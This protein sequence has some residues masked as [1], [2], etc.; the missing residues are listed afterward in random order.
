MLDTCAETR[1]SV[2]ARDD[3]RLF[4]CSFLVICAIILINVVVAVLLEKMV[5]PIEEY[6]E[7]EQDH[8]EDALDGLVL[9]DL[10]RIHPEPPP[11]TPPR[12]PDLHNTPVTELS[13]GNEDVTQRLTALE[14][15]VDRMLL[16]MERSMGYADANVGAVDLQQ[17]RQRDEGREV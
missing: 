10:K 7:E 14:A 16:M 4:F 17:A 6:E 3:I 12:S 1:L 9:P 13:A 11:E 2:C 5:E 15:K 8:S